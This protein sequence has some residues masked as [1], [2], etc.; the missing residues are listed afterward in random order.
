MCLLLKFI[1]RDPQSAVFLLKVSVQSSA[2][3][4]NVKVACVRFYQW[5]PFKDLIKS[6]YDGR[7]KE[8]IYRNEPF[9][10]V[11]AHIYVDL[12]TSNVPPYSAA[13]MRY[14]NLLWPELLYTT[15]RKLWALWQ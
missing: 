8:K 3:D 14:T 12:L 11:K 2:R 7:H 15:G 1:R 9:R 13:A 10:S 4:F 6:A 5:L